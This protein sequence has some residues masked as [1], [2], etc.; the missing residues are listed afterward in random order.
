L[1]GAGSLGGRNASRTRLELLGGSKGFASGVYRLLTRAVRNGDLS[2]D[3]K[4]AAVTIRPDTTLFA[5]S[6]GRLAVAFLAPRFRDTR[7]GFVTGFEEGA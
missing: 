2:R 6:A 4:R 3:Y 1:D 5:F 7:V